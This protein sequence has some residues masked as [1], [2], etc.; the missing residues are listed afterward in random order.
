[1]KRVVLITT[2]QPSTNPRIVKEADALFAAGYE[3]TLLYSFFIHWAS[4]KD[5]VLLQK[6]SWKYLMAGGSPDQKKSIY[7][8]KVQAL[9][10]VLWFLA[11]CQQLIHL[12]L[13]AKKHLSNSIELS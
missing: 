12:I 8:S 3:V 10:N 7:L 13:V 5:E 4:E 11:P 1:M 6:A 2:G 9:P